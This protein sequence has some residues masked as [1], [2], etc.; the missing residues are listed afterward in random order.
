M[1]DSWDFVKSEAENRSEGSESG[2]MKNQIT[3]S[4]NPIVFWRRANALQWYFPFKR[5]MLSFP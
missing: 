2:S 4:K 5:Q 1:E 3:A